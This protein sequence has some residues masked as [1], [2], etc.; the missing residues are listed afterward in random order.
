MAPPRSGR[1]QW[2][3]G[4]LDRDPGRNSLRLLPSGPD[5]VGEGPVRRQPPAPLYQVPPRRAQARVARV[6]RPRVPPKKDAMDDVNFY[7]GGGFDRAAPRRKDKDW[8]AALAAH[9]ESRFVAGVARAEPGAEGRRRRAPRRLPHTRR[10]RR[11]AAASR[12]CWAWSRSAP[13]SRSI[14]RTRTAP[15][16]AFAASQPLEFTDLRRVGPLL[17]R[18]EG[19]LLA[20]ARGIA[21][22]HERH[23]FCGVCGAATRERRR[24]PC[25]ALHQRRVRHRAF[26]AH[27]PGGDHAGA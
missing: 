25:P 14:C 18:Q 15:L 2:Q 11:R 21:Y 6:T 16:A 4:R 22:W 26:P 27:R 7:A 24:R 20:Y 9:G 19:A 3:G 10:A 5:R 12:C 17:P 13:I 8:V 23:R 1:A